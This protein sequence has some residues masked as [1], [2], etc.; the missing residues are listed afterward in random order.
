MVNLPLEIIESIISHISTHGDLYTC[1]FINKHFY[2]ATLPVLWHSPKRILSS[3]ASVFSQYRH[4]YQCGASSDILGLFGVSNRHHIRRLF[5]GGS[6]PVSLIPLFQPLTRFLTELVLSQMFLDDENMD[7]VARCCRHLQRITLHLLDWISWKTIVSL[8]R[9]CSQLTGISLTECP[10]IKAYTLLPLLKT[11]G[12]KQLTVGEV[13][14]EYEEDLCFVSTRTW[15]KRV[16]TRLHDGTMTTRMK[17]FDHFSF[18]TDWTCLMQSSS[19]WALQLTELCLHDINDEKCLIPLIE[20]HTRLEL[21]KMTSCRL[22]PKTLTAIA[23]SLF[24]LRHLDLSGSRRFSA[25]N[26]KTMLKLGC[27]KLDLIVLIGCQ[28]MTVDRLHRAD[29]ERWE[30][31]MCLQES[32]IPCTPTAQASSSAVK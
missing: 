27:P 21:L 26:L 29:F 22:G 24:D 25:H 10:K 1:L 18:I 31:D 19:E 13:P 5:I 17:K 3:P 28:T 11:N 15:H 8:S 4:V 30:P 16:P 12:L 9:Y 7:A 23:R 20:T 32:T 14:F 6:G 2:I